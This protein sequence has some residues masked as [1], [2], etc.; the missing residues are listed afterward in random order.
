M[1]AAIIYGLCGL[2]AT[3]CAWLLLQTHRQTGYR[4]L[5]WSGLFFAITAFNN[6][7]L[8]ADKLILPWMDLAVA[9]YA[10][11]LGALAVLLHG[12]IMDAE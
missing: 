7:L 12:L 5:F 8:M 6:L 3:L 10:I 11:S 4:L 9:R 2:T 1:T